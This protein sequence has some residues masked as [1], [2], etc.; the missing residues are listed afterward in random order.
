MVN[1]T[2]PP[3]PDVKAATAVA[4]NPDSTS[5][6]LESAFGASVATDRL[7]A[8]HL[9]A[10]AAMLEKLSH[11]SDKVTRKYV[12]LNANSSK[13]V[14]FKLAPQFPGDFFNNPAFD[15]LLLEE[16]DL[17]VHL[18]HG[19]LK[20]ILKRPDCP[21]SFMQWAAARGTEPEK[22]A[23]A[24]NPQASNDALALLVAEAG[25]VGQAARAHR[26]LERAETYDTPIAVLQNE[27]CSALRAMDASDARLCWRRTFIG[28]G[29][30]ACL[31]PVSRLAVLGLPVDDLVDHWLLTRA[32]VL[33][34]EGDVDVLHAVSKS[35]A[36]SVQLLDELAKHPDWKV[37]N[38]VAENSATSPASLL[39]LVNDDEYWVR[40][41][42]LGRISDDM[43]PALA[44]SVYSDVRRHVAINPS[45][46]AEC[47]EALARDS[48]HAVRV[49]VADNASAPPSALEF[50][51]EDQDD[52]IR[53]RVAG[54]PNASVA[55]KD[56]VHNGMPALKAPISRYRVNDVTMS[57][58]RRAVLL[59]ALVRSNDSDDRVF[60]ARH[61]EATVYE[62]DILSTDSHERTRRAVAAN[63][64]TP[65]F[66]LER[67]AKDSSDWVRRAVA[68]NS[69]LPS[70][71]F[72]ILSLD[73]EGA[74]RASLAKHL[75]VPSAVL[76]TL[77]N[78]ANADV[79]SS[80]AASTDAPVDILVRL[81]QDKESHVRAAVASN[82][83]TPSA[84]LELLAVESDT[85][86]VVAVVGNPSS[87]LQLLEIFAE[88]VDP[89]LRRAVSKNPALPSELR[90]LVLEGLIRD[91]SNIGHWVRDELVAN[92]DTPLALLDMIARKR[93]LAPP[94]LVNAAR[95]PM[96]AIDQLVKLSRSR[97]PKIQMAVAAN[98]A[99]PPE[100]RLTVWNALA[101]QTGLNGF[102]GFPEDLQVP[103]EVRQRSLQ[104][105]RARTWWHSVNLLYK[106]YKCTRLPNEPSPGELVDKFAKEAE[107]LLLRPKDSLVAQM[108][109]L[110]QHDALT[111][112]PAAVERA[113]NRPLHIKSESSRQLHPV[114][115]LGLSSPSVSFDAIIKRYRSV[116]WVERLA[117]AFNLNT[118]ANILVSL[119][120]DAHHL[121]CRQAGE[122]G[123][124]QETLAIWQ[125]VVLKT[126]DR[127]EG[128]ILYL[129]SGMQRPSTAARASPKFTETVR[130]AAETCLAL[131]DKW[132]RQASNAHDRDTQQVESSD[133]ISEW[134]GS[135]RFDVADGGGP[136][137]RSRAVFCLVDGVVT[138]ISP[139]YGGLVSR[140]PQCSGL[141]KETTFRFVCT[142]SAGGSAEGCGFAIEKSVWSRRLSLSEAEILLSE[143]RMGPLDGFL[144]YGGRP[145]RSLVELKMDADSNNWKLK[146]TN[147]D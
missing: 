66:V 128:Q 147:E 141:V 132:Q 103:Q 12:A 29:Q 23:V 80:V 53:R 107:L 34:D 38:S 105:K 119:I 6:Q 45:V 82:V 51:A 89:S 46:P 64:H 85:T 75:S 131:R 102:W 126:S 139:G 1:N 71:C 14:L 146:L 43:L 58:V 95:D 48:E 135:L 68:E 110:S 125:E 9:K 33:M 60:V 137:Y 129:L 69:C 136:G 74:V 120:K 57:A 28:P 97:K 133:E 140:C 94:S 15:W 30:W 96:T 24:M 62:L 52:E 127:W 115:L 87:P 65:G 92:P 70:A 76:E 39:V 26:N 13:E 37:R 114:R 81:S 86:V 72:G 2:S 41:G 88:S 83:R 142:G 144:T 19:V 99:T 47:L 93:G 8:R 21:V 32:Q 73:A 10:P 90:F 138:K 50:L 11:A 100:V 117:V 109:G 116:D 79:R 7:L 31:N 67:L 20:N 112:E 42:A 145:F 78:D 59:E 104:V 101:D 22:L 111:I 134:S 55:T 143:K 98:P 118:P 56:L 25:D 61:A 49:G 123:S 108:M 113:C 54:N 44:S 35:T 16:P 63:P 18:G 27:I 91:K 3:P 121:V 5:G 84:I 77:A 106:R 4:K 124:L 17:L 36:A 130:S 122:T 40:Q